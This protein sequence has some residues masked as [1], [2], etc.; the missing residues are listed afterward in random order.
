MKTL[1]P[2][3]R[4]QEKF[5][6][7]TADIAVFGGSAGGGKSFAVLLDILRYKDDP[8]YRAVVFRRT[9]PQL[10]A[11]GSIW[12]EAGKLFTLPGIDAQAKIKDLKYVF[13]SGAE[14]SFSHLEHEKDKEN[15]QG[16]QLSA[17]YFEE[18]THM[19]GSQ[20]TY[21]F[22]RLRSEA[23]VDGYIR[24][25][26]NPDPD[27]PLRKW[28]DWWIDKKTGLPIPERSGVLRYF[29]MLG[30][31][32]YWASSKELL[33]RDPDVIQAIGDP[34]TGRVDTNL[35]MSF[36]FIPATLNDNKD[37]LKA[38]PRYKAAL[39]AMGKVDR[40]RLL[41][42]N[43]NVRA[44]HGDYFHRN[45]VTVVDKNQIPSGMRTVRYW[46]RAG[47]KPNADNPNPDWTVGLLVGRCDLGYTWILDMIRL[48]DTPA[49]IQST[50]Q[51]AAQTDALSRVSTRITLEKDPGQAGKSD[52]EML[53]KALGNYDVRI[54]PATK[55]KLTRFMPFSAAAEN[56]LIRVVRAAWNDDFFNELEAFD[57]SGKGKDDIVD[58]CSGGYLELEDKLA[59]PDIIMPVNFGA[60]SNTFNI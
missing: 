54:R 52:A 3:S 13:P 7:T 12:Q 32:W 42:G 45:W 47:T 20:I 59:I 15:W 8:N 22:S 6:S 39:M 16:S 5:L 11:P 14:V 25:T 37:M 27:H 26:C 56:G 51:S 31:E 18:A 33:L 53:A 48:R 35:I 4:P 44:S 34:E 28:I 43:W 57:G 23:E 10:L 58:C 41:G 19:S 21:M 50:I 40:E 17:V 9:S 46:D 30:D 29:V 24:M 55:S 1:R 36:T 49:N 38:N 2:N 60:T